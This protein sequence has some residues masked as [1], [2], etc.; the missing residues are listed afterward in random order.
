MT[1]ETRRSPAETVSHEHVAAGDVASAL[2]VI[3]ACEADLGYKLSDGQRRDLVCDNFTSWSW[4]YVADVVASIDAKWF[5]SLRPSEQLTN[6]Q[7]PE[8]GK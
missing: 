6:C 4:Q 2:D 5:T 8:A 3:K 7:R 1:D